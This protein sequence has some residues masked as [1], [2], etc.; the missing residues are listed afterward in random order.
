M[1]KN[2]TS[3]MYCTF[4]Q[5]EN[6]PNGTDVLGTLIPGWQ[7]MPVCKEHREA[8]RKKHNASNYLKVNDKL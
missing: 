4:C 3:K 6:K 5:L 2:L 1:G 7:W 8:W